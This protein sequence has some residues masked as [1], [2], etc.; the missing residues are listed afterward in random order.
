MV[1]VLQGLSF[2]ETV[3]AGKK[4]MQMTSN[5]SRPDRHPHQEGNLSHC[6]SNRGDCHIVPSKRIQCISNLEIKTNKVWLAKAR[7]IKGKSLSPICR[8]LLSKSRLTRC[9]LACFVYPFLLAV[10]FSMLELQS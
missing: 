9:D 7:D 3:F 4:I 8:S 1:A 6:N 10:S 5:S 2:D